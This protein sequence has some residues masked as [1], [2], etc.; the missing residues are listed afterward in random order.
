MLV[1]P[2][3]ARAAWAATQ[4]A[5]SSAIP[6]TVLLDPPRLRRNGIRLMRAAEGGKSTVLVLGENQDPDLMVS[7]RIEVLGN[8]R[9]R[10]HTN[11]NTRILQTHG[12]QQGKRLRKGTCPEE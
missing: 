5:G 12:R 7:L 3:A 4:L 11:G 2:G 9:V 1:R 6:L 10:A 8:G